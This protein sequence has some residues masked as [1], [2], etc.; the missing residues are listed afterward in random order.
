MTAIETIKKNSVLVTTLLTSTNREGNKMP[1]K[2]I[3]SILGI[4]NNKT[5]RNRLSDFALAN[6]CRR[7]KHHTRVRKNIVTADALFPI[8]DKE[9]FLAACKAFADVFFKEA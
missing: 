6:N 1:Y 3:L 2:D 9:R 4:E 7:R 5:N 8:T